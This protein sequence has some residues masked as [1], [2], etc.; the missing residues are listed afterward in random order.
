MGNTTISRREA[1]RQDQNE[2]LYAGIKFSAAGTFAAA[3]V[4]VYTFGPLANEKMAWMW[5]ILVSVIYLARIV[6]NWLYR[7]SNSQKAE[8][9][10]WQKR[11]NAGAISSAVAWA[12]SVWMIFPDNNPA[13]QV[14]LILTLGGVAG[15]ALASLP[16]DKLL[17]KLFQLIIILSVEIKL[18]SLGDPFSLQLAVFCLFVF[19]F[20]LSCGTEVG[21]NYYDLLCFR[22]DTQETNST[23]IKTTERMAQIGYWQ[24]NMRT[25]EIELS[26]NMAQIWGSTSRSLSIAKCF[27]YLHRNDRDRVKHLFESVVTDQ[28]EEAEIEYRMRDLRNGVYRYMRQ[29]VKKISDSQGQSYLVGTVQDISDIKSAEEKIY[30]MAYFDDL[31]G[32]ANRAS[33]HEKL[34][35]QITVALR[36]QNKF[37]IIYIDLDDFKGVNDAYGHECGDNYLKYFSQYLTENMRRTDVIARLGGDEFCILMTDFTDRKELEFSAARCLDFMNFPIQIGNHRIHPKLSIGISIYPTDAT[38]ADNLV[39]CA[40]TAMYTVK[41]NGKHDYCFFEAKMLSDIS[42]RV[43]LEADLKH[44]LATGQFELWYQ[45]KISLKDNRLSGVEALIRWRHPTKG[46]IPPDLFI[47]TAERVGMIKDIGEW[48]LATACAQLHSWNAQGLYIDMAVNISCDHF[49]V[50]GFPTFVIDTINKHSVD[51]KHLEIEITESLTRDS[52]EHT[53]ICHELRA[54]GVRIAIDDFGTGYSS[55]SVLAKLEV[56][57]LKIDQSFISGLPGDDSSRL[58]VKAITDLSLGLGYDVVAEGVE[59]AEQLAF[60]QS[61]GCP[62]VQGYFLCRPV[63]A[64][65]IPDLANSVWLTDIKKAA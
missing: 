38:D 7:Q 62:Y 36:K 47:S 26:E 18:L 16:Y 5:L 9:R 11:F 37:A 27:R 19:G 54:F 51:S 58:M 28:T 20:L 50:S 6:D 35:Q 45:P 59:T 30:N 56:D 15:G 8:A 25:K 33:F 31:T 34:Q 65:K 55:L 29:V 48:V 43:K 42:E 13:Y 44:S 12:T 46:I 63:M 39:M 17:I 21:K 14:L 64:E 49:R 32:L 41:Q 60:L 53:K 4:V 22:Q 40:D 1:I 10:K 52:D 3:L 2:L 61:L 23:I 24:W 57:T